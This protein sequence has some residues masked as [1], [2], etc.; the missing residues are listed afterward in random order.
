VFYPDSKEETETLQWISTY[1]KENK[2]VYFLYFHTKGITHYSEPTEDWRKYM[3]YFVIGNH[4]DCIAKLD[5]G[6]D[7]C[8]VMWNP[9]ENIQPSHRKGKSDVYHHF[10]G[11][12]WWATA[13]YIN[14]LDDSYLTED[15]RYYRE[16][17]IGSA[18]QRKVHEFHNSRFNDPKSLKALGGHYKRLYKPEQYM[19]RE[20]TIHVICTAYKRIQTLQVLINCMLLQTLDNWKLY[21]VHDG[22]AS[23]EMTKMVEPYLSDKTSFECT[24]QV[25]GSW[26]HP[27]RGLMLDKLKANDD[28]YVLITNDDNYYVQKFIEFMLFQTASNVG[29]VY[30]DTLHSYLQYAAH[31]STIRKNGIDMGAFVV[32][33]PIAKEVGFKSTVFEADGIYAERCGALCKQ[34]N[35]KMMYIP[36]TLFIHN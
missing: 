19:K 20:N 15:W 25:N 28:D 31:K 11:G 13:E 9:T 30:C 6:F 29:I 4:K 7:C 24:P 34:R 16:F 33:Y 1:A 32:S 26:G 17:W 27:N 21:I 35:L 23:D 5:E 2:V 14:R 22:P 8:G 18:Q 3:Q 12:M 10:S 36:K